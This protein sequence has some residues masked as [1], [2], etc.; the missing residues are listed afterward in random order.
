[1]RISFTGDIMCELPTLRKSK[2]KNQYNFDG[3][4]SKSNIFEK[5]DYLVGNLETVLA[6]K[7]AKY[8][9]DIYSYNTPD[10]FADEL[11]R[12]KFDLLSTANNHCLDRGKEGLLRTMNTL[13]KKKIDY[14][15]TNIDK[16]GKRFK[17]IEINNI[18][19]GFLAYTYGSNYS[20]NKNMLSAED[21]YMVNF[22]EKQDWLDNS[23]K[24]IYSKLKE[25]FI[26]AENRVR[27]MKILKKEYNRPRI[28]DKNITEINKNLIEDISILKSKVDYIVLL[29]HSGGQF[30]IKPG[31]YTRKLVE[32][33]KELGVDLVIGHHPHIVQE[34]KIYKDFFVAY[35]LG[36]FF[37]SPDTIYLINENLP[38]YSIVL[39]LDI[40]SNIDYQLS[41]SIAKIVKTNGYERVVNVYDLLKYENTNKDKLLKDCEKIYK[42]FTGMKSVNFDIKKEYKLMME[43]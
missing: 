29:M 24:D 39:H 15:G 14:I 25:K 38:M 4:L 32:K 13:N 27:L 33:L 1:M 12:A 43:K 6:G 2:I 21:E 23:R 16:N 20:I 37:M 36:N 7:D 10:S 31:V 41:F 5:T 30:N 18:K 9:Y 11:Y 22:F 8:S 28:D 35:S 34:C 26:S 17:I 19:I 40:I 42:I 3:A